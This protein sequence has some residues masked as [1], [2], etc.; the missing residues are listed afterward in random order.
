MFRVLTIL[1]NAN[2]VEP[3]AVAAQEARYRA[4]AQYMRTLRDGGGVGIDA[5]LLVR[6]HHSKI[7][8]NKNIL[9]AVV[10]LPAGGLR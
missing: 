3:A 2:T 4:D 8:K 5:E 10:D 6:Q 1:D 9:H 7:A